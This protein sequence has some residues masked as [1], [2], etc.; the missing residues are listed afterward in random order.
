VANMD[1]ARFA[2]L[3]NSA[4]ARP[5]LSEITEAQLEAVT[6]G[7]KAGDAGKQTDLGRRLAGLSGDD[8]YRAA[9]NLVRSHVSAVLGHANQAAVDPERGFMELGFDSLTALEMRTRLADETGLR[10][11]ATLLFDYPTPVALA[12]YLQAELGVASGDSLPLPILAEIDRLA[13]TVSRT[14]DQQTRT[15]AAAK[16]Q[17]VLATLTARPDRGDADV[18]SAT[19]DELFDILDNEL[20]TP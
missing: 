12:R 1:W 19:D 11:P 10:L 7:E 14:E 2:Q 8:L 20:D 9:L 15:A 16:L 13:E 6:A 17:Q 4:R 3:F 18:R 5:L